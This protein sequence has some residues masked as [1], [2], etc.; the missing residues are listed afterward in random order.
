MEYFE[1]ITKRDKLITKNLSLY[2]EV[3]RKSDEFWEI[4]K[5]DD[6]DT[7]ELY[8]E[9]KILNINEVIDPM[10]FIPKI[11]GVPVITVEGSS[12][13]LSNN[14]HKD[15][16]SNDHVSERESC[17][18]LDVKNVLGKYDARGKMKICTTED[19]SNLFRFSNASFTPQVKDIE[20]KVHRFSLNKYM[21]AKYGITTDLSM[22]RKD[23]DIPILSCL[24]PDVKSTTYS[25]GLRVHCFE[26]KSLELMNVIYTEALKKLEG[27]K[28]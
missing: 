21:K 15:E 20:N 2:N 27:N 17:I 1:K 13:R 11:D 18:I 3:F 28:G 12:V 5:Y 8:A 26:K 6:R 10:P 19:A 7:I 14:V 9:K 25:S 24:F 16:D 4:M 22:E 23:M